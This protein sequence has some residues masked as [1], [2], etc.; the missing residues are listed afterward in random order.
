MIQTSY[1]PLE[2]PYHIIE[3]N[4]NLG[5]QIGTLLVTREKSC[6]D[7]DSYAI[8]THSHPV[9][10]YINKRMP[11]ELKKH[12]SLSMPRPFE[13]VVWDNVELY[14]LNVITRENGELTWEDFMQLCKKL[15]IRELENPNFDADMQIVENYGILR[16]W[17][18]P[19]RHP[20]RNRKGEPTLNVE[21]AG[22]LQVNGKDYFHTNGD[23]GIVVEYADNDTMF[24]NIIRQAHSYMSIMEGLGLDEYKVKFWTQDIFM[25]DLTAMLKRDEKSLHYPIADNDPFEDYGWMAAEDYPP[26]EP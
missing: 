26:V 25:Q 11:L 1:V 21:V 5:I 24:V 4:G 23:M 19:I 2:K 14:E 13:G 6:N 22:R 12:M 17:G 20:K 9:V 10:S 3:H 7:D 8:E 18:I 16:D 15:R